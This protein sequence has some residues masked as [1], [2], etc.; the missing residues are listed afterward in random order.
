MSGTKTSFPI[1]RVVLIG[2][3][4]ALVFALSWI[5]IP[6]PLAIGE[7]TRIHFGNIMC[8]LAGV[9]FGPLTGGLSAGIGSMLF[10]FSHPEYASEFW[11]TFITKFAM[12]FVA[13]VLA[14]HL[15][16]KIP[17][18]P[19]QLVGAVCGQAAYI[20]LYMAKTFLQQRYL[21][22]IQLELVW[23]ILLGKL[24]ASAANGLIAVVGCVI[25]APILKAALDK[26]GLFKALQPRHSEKQ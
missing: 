25:L 10:D 9:L 22:K 6:I 7:N 12:G 21:Y 1:R 5:S 26:A 8:L 20:V 11:I 3:F 4:A 19:R 2:V 14:R 18:F 17:V 16:K 23:P 24:L 13:G 15:P